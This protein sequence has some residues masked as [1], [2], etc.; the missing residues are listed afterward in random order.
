MTQQSPDEQTLIERHQNSPDGH[1][2][3]KKSHFVGP[4][5][6]SQIISTIYNCLASDKTGELIAN[7]DSYMNIEQPLKLQKS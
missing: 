6:S 5:Q 4:G 1:E 2:V 3:S 7:F